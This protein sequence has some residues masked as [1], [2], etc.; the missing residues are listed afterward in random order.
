[1]DPEWTCNEEVECIAYVSDLL[2]E[3]GLTDYWIAKDSIA[4]NILTRCASC[5][6]GRPHHKKCQGWQLSFRNATALLLKPMTHKSAHIFRVRVEGNFDTR[7]IGPKWSPWPTAPNQKANAAIFVTSDSGEILT[8][9]HLDLSN[10]GQSGPVWH[11]QL[12][13]LP[14]DPTRTLEWLDVPRWPVSPFDFVLVIELVIFT[15]A[16][17]T[18][19]DLRFRN[20]WRQWVQRS[21]AL[22]LPHYIEAMNQYSDQPS[23]FASWLAVQ[24]NQTGAINPRP[25]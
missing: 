20:P 12:S 17:D 4:D 21:E 11:L 16:W 18:W 3:T 14:D 2:R 24:C 23:R 7:R 5:R 13:A 8:R 6:A 22:V 25:S 1:L 15:F 10:P 9:H 19:K